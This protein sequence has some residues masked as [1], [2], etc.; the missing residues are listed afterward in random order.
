MFKILWR[1]EDNLFRLETDDKKEYSIPV[2]IHADRIVRID[3]TL[4]KGVRILYDE[5]SVL[6]EY[7]FLYDDVL[8][9]VSFLN[10]STTDARA[11]ELDRQKRPSMVDQALTKFGPDSVE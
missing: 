1:N 5:K 8:D 6:A 11:D 7:F 10:H 4:V 3:K 9:I 2:G